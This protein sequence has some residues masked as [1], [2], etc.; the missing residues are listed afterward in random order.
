MVSSHE[1][2]IGNADCGVAVRAM[3]KWKWKGSWYVGGR[4]SKINKKDI[5]WAT[6]EEIEGDCRWQR[7]SAELPEALPLLALSVARLRR[8]LS[9]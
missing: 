8:T 1:G 3:Q 9:T 2:T 5:S 4:V 6:E 7:E